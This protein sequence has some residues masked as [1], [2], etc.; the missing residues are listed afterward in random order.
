MPQV[1]HIRSL[2][3]ALSHGSLFFGIILYTA[4]GAKVNLIN[5]PL[6]K[7]FSKYNPGSFIQ[8]SAKSEQILLLRC[9]IFFAP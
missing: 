6:S 9:I 1:Q 7:N 2:R 3:G 4:L 5:C 8:F